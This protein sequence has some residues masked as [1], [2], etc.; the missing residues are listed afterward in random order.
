LVDL[1]EFFSL[2]F[3]FPKY[4]NNQ[5]GS[6]YLIF[7]FTSKAKF[8]PGA[9]EQLTKF[10]KRLPPLGL[11]VCSVRPSQFHV[12]AYTRNVTKCTVGPVASRPCPLLVFTSH[13]IFVHHA[14]KNQKFV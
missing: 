11:R 4:S 10:G 1:F 7:V 13:S 5:Y 8:H 14:A 3:V 2:I 6:K 12:Q 9:N